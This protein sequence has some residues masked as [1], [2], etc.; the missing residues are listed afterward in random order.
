[1]SEEDGGVPPSAIPVCPGADEDTLSPTHLYCLRVAESLGPLPRVHIGSIHWSS[2]RSFV[3]V[4]GGGHSRLTTLRRQGA[5][6]GRP[7]GS[8]RTATSADTVPDEVGE[9]YIC[10]PGPSFRRP[11][12]SARSGHT[13]AFVAITLTGLLRLVEDHRDESNPPT[14]HGRCHSAGV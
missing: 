11:R 14:S 9:L 3:I 13:N 2:P 12:S 4:S 6:L 1:M 8:T 10:T 5:E 7:V